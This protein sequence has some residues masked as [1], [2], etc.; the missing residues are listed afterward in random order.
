M[1]DALDGAFVCRVGERIDE[2]DGERLDAGLDE[3][4]DDRAHLL[5]VQRRDHLAL[6]A[7]ALACLARVFESGGR[8]GLDHDDVAGQGTGRL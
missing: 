2:R 4:A 6:R 7:H 3:L 8:V 5:L 1:D